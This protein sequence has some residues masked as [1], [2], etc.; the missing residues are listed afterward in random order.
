MT[1]MP[2]RLAVTGDVGGHLEMLSRQLQAVGGDIGGGDLLVT[3]AGLTLGAWRL[4]SEPTS[5]SAIVESLNAPDCRVVGRKGLLLTGNADTS[6]GPLWPHSVEELYHSWYMRSRQDD[7]ANAPVFTQAHGH[8]SAYSWRFA[9]WALGLEWL[10]AKGAVDL[11]MDIGRR[12]T[13]VGIGERTFFGTDPDASLSD[14][15]VSD[16]L[17]FSL[18]DPAK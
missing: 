4:M 17:T 3:H 10:D 16:P 15:P 12:V 13:R 11:R 6:A 1:A 2:S 14:A 7:D 9:H 18:A 5:V 8:T